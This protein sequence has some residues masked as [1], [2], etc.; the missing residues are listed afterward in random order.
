[1]PVA[2]ARMRFRM[3]QRKELEFQGDQD[4]PAVL[5]D[6]RVVFAKRRKFFERICM[7]RGEPQ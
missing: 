4:Q 5:G 3:A 1:M 7:L 2:Q 6:F